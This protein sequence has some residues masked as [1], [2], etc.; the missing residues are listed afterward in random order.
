MAWIRYLHERIQDVRM[1]K[2]VPVKSLPRTAAKGNIRYVFPYPPPSSRRPTAC[3]SRRRAVEQEYGSDLEA[4]YA[5]I[6]VEEVFAGV[7]SA[8]ESETPGVKSPGPIQV[9]VGVAVAA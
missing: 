2:V 8:Q 3:Q 6:P 7:L 9:S 5:S 4:M 1:I